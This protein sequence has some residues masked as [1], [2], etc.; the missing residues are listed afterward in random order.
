MTDTTKICPKCGNT[1]LVGLGRYHEKVCTDH[2]PYVRIP[3]YTDE[4][5]KPLYG[6]F[7]L[8]E[9]EMDSYEQD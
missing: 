4:G 3:W 7:D 9:E 6:N 1:N 5:Q 8:N 2:N